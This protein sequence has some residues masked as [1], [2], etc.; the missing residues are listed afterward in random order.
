MRWYRWN[1]YKHKGAG[2]KGGQLKALVDLTTLRCCNRVVGT[3]F[4]V[5]NEVAKVALVRSVVLHTYCAQLPS[6]C[7]RETVH[8]LVQQLDDEVEPA[9]VEPEQ[10]KPKPKTSTT[11]ELKNEP[12]PE[13]K[14]SET[15]E[16][17]EIRETNDSLPPHQNNSSPSPP[18]KKANQTTPPDT[19]QDLSVPKT[20][21][22]GV[23]EDVV[24]DTLPVEPEPLPQPMTQQPAQQ[25]APTPQSIPR[26]TIE[27]LYNANPDANAFQKQMQELL[28][29]SPQAN[30]TG[31]GTNE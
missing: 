23:N 28:G 15:N 24:D 9:V 2:E 27:Y 12:K 6:N 21:T 8:T 17:N 30:L 22:K 18:S 14:T 4:S 19:T 5:F 10:P 26:K 16:T 11:T 1:R 3:T 13:L 29:L 7:T 31:G 20:E 25:P